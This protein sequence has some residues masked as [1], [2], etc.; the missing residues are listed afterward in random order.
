[1]T[2]TLFVRPRLLVAL[3]GLLAL[4][5][6]DLNAQTL[7]WDPNPETN[8]AGYRVYQG[9]SAG[10]Y[11]TQV[12][13]GNVTSYPPQGVDWSRRA[14]FAV[15]AINSAGLESGFS[16][17]VVWTPPSVTTVTA[18]TPNSAYPVAVG[19]S[20]TWTA[21]GSNNLGP[22]EYR[23]WMYKKSAWVLAQDYS[24][25]NT[26][27]WAPTVADQGSPYHVQVWARRVGSTASYEAWLGTPAFDVTPPPLALAANVDFPTPPGNQVTWTATVG[28]PGAPLEFQF[29]VRNTSTSTWT[30]FRSYSPGNKAQWTP[31]TAGSYIV[32]AWARPVGSTAQFQHSASSPTF[33]V[34]ASA[35]TLTAF[36][37]NTTSPALTGTPITWT[38]RVQGGTAGPLQYQ[39]WLYSAATGWR[40]V[41][42]YGPT[43]TFTWTPTWGDEGDYWL[44]VWARSNGSTSSYEHWRSTTAAFQVQPAAIHL[45][46]PTWFPS[47]PS[48]P[49]AWSANVPS[50][51]ANME[52]QFSVASAATAQ[53]TVAQAYSTQK[54]FT[55]LPGA[56]GTYFVRVYARQVG[57][58]APVE[59]GS[60][61]DL[62]EVASSPALTLGLISNV[63]LPAAAGTTITWRASA[64]GG[65]AQLQ[66]QFW[67]QDG[68]AW[69]LAQD[70]S[71]SP[72]YTWV[73]TAASVGQH[74]V[75]VRV[76]SLGS[77]QSLE[78]QMTTGVFSI[79]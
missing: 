76:R 70:Y 37:T 10:T 69:V 15:K 59:L 56:P 71:A 48:A 65:T 50:P 29:R 49:V 34:G 4:T 6:T 22:V 5:T 78:S 57:S 20:I 18:L 36:S 31:T 35:L 64:S 42:P 28:S 66:Y 3:A 32:E 45:T 46:T 19:S 52:Y 53:W 23:F 74:Q 30:I 24:S 12:N 17:E 11:T 55:W 38:A 14:Y 63:A 2:Q 1:M 54:T 51:T 16:N 47:A 26:L 43:E 73:T 58:T 39:F 44:Q 21:T 41:Q 60:Q 68:T 13:V 62:L 25:S 77:S 61:R 7:A 72:T 40:N 33:S 75:Q 8:I 79:Q 27:T 9:T 67:R